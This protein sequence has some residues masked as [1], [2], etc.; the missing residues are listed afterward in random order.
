MPPYGTLALYWHL[1]ARMDG[2]DFLDGTH[3]EEEQIVARALDGDGYDVVGISAPFT[4]T[5]HRVLKVGDEL[6]RRA[7]STTLVAGGAHATFD[8]DA[9]FQ[10]GFDFVARRE[11]ELTLEELLAYLRGPRQGGADLAA[12]QGLVYLERGAP[13]LTADRPLLEDLDTLAMPDLEGLDLDAY[14]MASGERMF[15]LETSRGCCN[16]C[17]FCYTPNM[18]RRWRAKSPSRVAEEYSYYQ[19]QGIEYLLLTD[20]NFAVSPR[21]VRTITDAL[22]ALPERIPWEAPMCQDTVAK[23]PDLPARLRAAGC[24]T[25]QSA[26][27]SASEEVLAYYGKPTSRKIMNEAFTAMREAGVVVNTQVI[28][29]A[30][31]ESLAQV[32]SSLNFGRKWA[33]VLTISTLEPRPGTAFW[34]DAEPDQFQDFGKGISLLHPHP[35]AVEAMVIAQYLLFYL[36]PVTVARAFFGSGAQQRQLRWHMLMYANTALRKLRELLPHE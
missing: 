20:D 19:A 15:L 36:H 13:R 33:D 17:K 32:W 1:K 7:P 4:A 22:T 10:H 29:G 26:I 23:S 28:V 24:E 16:S 35:R 21:R 12:I 8:H 27:D 11:G 30:P 25:I 2:V 34:Q 14:R 3:L 31:V 6:R 5:V 9:F 18:W